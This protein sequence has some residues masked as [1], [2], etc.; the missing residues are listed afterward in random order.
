MLWLSS[1]STATSNIYVRCSQLNF[2][3]TTPYESSINSLFTSLVDSAS[4]YNF[5]KFEISPQNDAV[6]GLFQCRGD[7]NSLNCK[8]CVVSAI[9]ELKTACPMSTGGEIQFEG[10][11]VKY[12]N[13][14]FFGVQEKTEVYRRCGPSIGY[15]SDVLNRIDGALAYLVGGNGQYYRGVV[16]GSIEGVA[17]C[18]QDLSLSDCQDCLSEAFAQ[19][20]TECETSTW[21]DMYFGKCYI[22]Y[23][24]HG[25]E[26]V[27]NKSSG[28]GNNKL[29]WIGYIIAA[30]VG[31][32]SLAFG[33]IFAIKNPY[34]ISCEPPI[35]R[36]DVGPG[37]AIPGPN[38]TSWVYL[39]DQDIVTIC[40]DVLRRL[41][42]LAR[43]VRRW[44]AGLTRKW[45]ARHVLPRLA[46]HGKNVQDTWQRQGFL[47]K[48]KQGCLIETML[49]VRSRPDPTEQ[50]CIR[51]STFTWAG[52]VRTP[53]SF[54]MRKQ[55]Q[56]RRKLCVPSSHPCKM[57]RGLGVL[58]VKYLFVLQGKF[59]LGKLSTDG[60]V[61]PSSVITLNLSR[62]S[63]M[64]KPL[65]LLLNTATGASSK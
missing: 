51:C 42:K 8:D 19:L 13:M 39:S 21:G 55:F 53:W 44:L 36:V 64:A 48:G 32:G 45:F 5:N 27:V 63:G 40:K 24:D 38:K 33:L 54:I 16:F 59:C 43:L 41:L 28:G 1:V 26:D 60:E 52:Q 29:K 7:L 37:F 65:G 10:C 6:Y 56:G 9:S 62:K 14:S 2:T 11:Y 47:G 49:Y 12:D 20:R 34:N 22:R 25:K 30:A 31:G 50:Y 17:Q 46:R 61:L 4:M 23:A 58:H 35:Y 18:V 3:L 57:E 15:N